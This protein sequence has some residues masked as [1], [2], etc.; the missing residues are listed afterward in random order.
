MTPDTTTAHMPL[1]A[2][3][4]WG[5]AERLVTPLAGTARAGPQRATVV[6]LAGRGSSVSELTLNVRTWR[7]GGGD[8]SYVSS[9]DA[10]AQVNGQKVLMLGI[11]CGPKHGRIG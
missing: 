8:H 9:S 1:P 5:S 11:R 10:P 3:K 2:S 6:S 7:D 4:H